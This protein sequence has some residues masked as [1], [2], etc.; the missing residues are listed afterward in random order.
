MFHVDKER[1]AWTHMHIVQSGH[2]LEAWL[3]VWEDNKPLRT[4]L[5]ATNKL[6]NNHG[7]RLIELPGGSINKLG[8]IV[9]EQ[10]TISSLNIKLLA[11][12]STPRELFPHSSQV[13]ICSGLDP[14]EEA[15]YSI[16]YTILQFRL[17]E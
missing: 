2:E 8:I 5:L 15:S 6:S 16:P 1:G 14:G 17:L 9:G 3:V 10:G 12:L 7:I 11:D 4:N 13:L